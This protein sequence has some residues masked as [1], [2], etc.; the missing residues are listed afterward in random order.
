[1]FA[2]MLK[3]RKER[4]FYFSLLGYAEEEAKTANVK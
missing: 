1:M 3:R 2:E 4:K